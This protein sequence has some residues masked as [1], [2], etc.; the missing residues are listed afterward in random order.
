MLHDHQIWYLI[1]LQNNCIS[2]HLN[3]MTNVL[4]NN[5]SPRSSLVFWR[6]GTP[7][8]SRKALSLEEGVGAERRR[9]ISSLFKKIMLTLNSSFYLSDNSTLF[10]H[11]PMISWSEIHTEWIFRIYNLGYWQSIYSSFFLMVH[12]SHRI[13]TMFAVLKQLSEK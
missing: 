11:N 13:I 8:R 12:I 6:N 1:G 7:L 5:N 2:N 3:L 9:K 10:Y 4:F